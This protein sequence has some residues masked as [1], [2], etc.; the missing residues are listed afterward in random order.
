MPRAKRPP[1]KPP[2]PPT[3]QELAL[4]QHHRRV[5]LDAYAELGHW[6][7]ALREAQLPWRVVRNWMLSDPEFAEE[8]EFAKQRYV[9][10]LCRA[11]HQRAV[12]GWEVPIVGGQFR[13]EVVAHERRYS[14]RLLEVMLKR[15]DPNFRENVKVEQTT[16]VNGSVSHKHELNLSGLSDSDLRHAL[17]L[18]GEGEP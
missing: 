10:N 2:E 12:E 15:H 14:D 4:V 1:R 18:L 13:D 9:G 5:F 3:S 16:T 17:A 8:V 11:A 7:P 6:A